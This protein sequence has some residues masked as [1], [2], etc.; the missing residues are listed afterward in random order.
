MGPINLKYTEQLIK[1]AVLAYW[2][3][4]IGIALPVVIAFLTGYWLFLIYE[5]NQSWVVGALG[6]ALV[7]GYLM[8]SAL[9]FVQLNRALKRLR[10]MKVP[11]ATLELDSHR[12]KIS[13]DVGTSEIEWSQIIKVWRFESVWL[14]FFS[15]GEFMTLPTS[16]FTEESKSLIL[17]ILNSHGA[18][19]A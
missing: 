2:R 6:T 1:K 12:F 5:G 4:E 13:S 19:V 14:V 11:E 3:K 7:L 18:T 10:R 17:S 16:E 9:Y 8:I 15:A